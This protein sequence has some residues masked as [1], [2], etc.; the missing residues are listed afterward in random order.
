[1]STYD[2]GA[3]SRGLWKRVSCDDVAPGANLNQRVIEAI[4]E[5][6]GE[7]KG[8]EAKSFVSEHGVEQL[9]RA[10]EATDVGKIRDIALERLRPILLR[11]GV[12]IGRELLDWRSDFY[13]DDYLIL[14]INFPYEIAAKA[15]PSAE[16]PGIGR[17]TPSV[18][19]LAESRKTRD[20]V[21]DPRSYHRGHPPAAWA[22]GP[23]R[24][25][26]A[27]HSRDG[28]NVWWAVS[29][30]PAEAGMVLYEGLMEVDLPCD[31]R[32]LYVSAGYELPPPTA[33]P[34]APG[35][36]LVFDPEVLHGTHL[37][38][39]DTTRVA[40]SLRLNANR[41]QFDPSCFYAREFWRRAS[42]IEAGKLDEVLHLKREENLATPAPA[43]PQR[44]R[45][46]S[47]SVQATIEDGA[48]CIARKDLPAEGSRIF[49]SAGEDRL[50]VV[51]RNGEFTAFS[52]L[53][54][55]YGLDLADGAFVDQTS[56]C[57]GCGV[58]FDTTSG[59]SSTPS[60]RLAPLGL[61]ADDDGLR[62]RRPAEAPLARAS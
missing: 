50:M 37:N 52:A 57:P 60:L 21:Y 46:R 42:S 48:I 14:R 7:V 43:L 45:E 55:H 23:H 3:A 54:P 19:E 12:S 27:G 16:N 51:R 17:V 13:I 20:G 29:D 24:D 59:C 26:W 8:Q 2:Q 4:C 62:V 41:P 1:M 28:V 31:R 61:E 32:S 11:F 40:V 53:C 58:G 22:H 30:V 38:V 47:P 5:A 10:I 56:Y 36:M 18:K 15:D 35:Q 6:V 25:S 49:V 44:P 39:T 34:L 9:H 33:L